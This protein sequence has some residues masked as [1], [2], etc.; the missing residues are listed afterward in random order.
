MEIFD[1][2]NF[3]KDFRLL[4]FSIIYCFDVKNTSWCYQLKLFYNDLKS[5]N[6]QTKSTSSTPDERFRYSNS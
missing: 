3:T 5:I 6:Y 2:Q 1:L 4:P